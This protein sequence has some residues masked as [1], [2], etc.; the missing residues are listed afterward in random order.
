MNGKLN[1]HEATM[2][3]NRY[4][5]TRV[6]IVTITGCTVESLLDNKTDNGKILQYLTE[7]TEDVVATIDPGSTGL[8]GY[9]NGEYLDGSGWVPEDDYVPT[10]RPWYRQTINSDEEITLESV[11]KRFS[12]NKNN[13]NDAFNNELSM[14]CMAY[15]E[16]L[17]VSRAK[18]EL[19]FGDESISEISQ[20][21]GY[22]DTG[23]FSKV[24]KKHTGQTPSEYRRQMKTL[25]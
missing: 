7:E 1:T 19:Q 12:V 21:C 17:R 15:L 22:D 20:T 5:I 2:E 10:E 13:L 23:Y 11:L 18:K 4:L 3:Y 16:Y 14:S 9:I 24:F 25:C 6:D 8:Y